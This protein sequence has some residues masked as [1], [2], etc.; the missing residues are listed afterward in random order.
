MP[1]YTTILARAIGGA[2][3]ILLMEVL[4]QATQSPMAAIPFATSIVL[5]MGSPDAPPARLRCLVGGHVVCATSGVICTLL[6][7]FDLWVAALAIGLAI[8]VMHL[9][10]VFHPPAGIS[11]IVIATTKASPLF[12]VSPVMTGATILALYAILFHRG[13]GEK[14]PGDW[15]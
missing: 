9:L 3:A 13:T 14:W 11:P 8:A 1:R 2:G 12:I 5:V 6:F 15:R 10:D 7:G 4:A